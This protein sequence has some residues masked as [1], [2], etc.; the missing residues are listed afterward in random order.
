MCLIKECLLFGKEENYAAYNSA[1]SS[2]MIIT[3]YVNVFH[4]NSE[5]K[6]LLATS[7]LTPLNTLSS[8]GFAGERLVYQT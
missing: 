4:E 2:K 7:L 3:N 6:T 8:K 1:D 5:F